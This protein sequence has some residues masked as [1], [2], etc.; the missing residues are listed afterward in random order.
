MIW[1]TWQVFVFLVVL[2]W[3]HSSALPKPPQPL[4]V[5]EFFCGTAAVSK[6]T[7]FAHIATANLDIDMGE[8][9]RMRGRR[10]AFDLTLTSGLAFSIFAY[11]SFCPFVPCFTMY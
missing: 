9:G 5:I 8:D 3:F 11:N 1:Q 7:R 2:T 10:N 4:N 6:S